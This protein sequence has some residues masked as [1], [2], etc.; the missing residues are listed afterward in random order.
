MCPKFGPS[1]N[2]EIF[3]EQGYKS[4]L[5]APEWLRIMG[6]DLYEYPC[7]RGIHI[8]QETAGKLKI[9][10]SQN[11]IE[12]SIHAPYY[13]NLASQDS[14]KILNSI[15]YI[16]KSVEAARWMGAK[17]V[18]FHP[19]SCAKIDREIAMRTVIESLKKTINIMDEMHYD[20]VIICPETM[21]KRNQI[22]TLDE[23]MELCRLDE[24]LIPTID[25]GHLN[26]LGRGSLKDREDYRKVLLKIKNSLGEFRLKNIHSHF[27]RIEYTDAGEKKHWTLKDEQYGPDFEPLAELLVEYQINATI[28]CESRGTMAEDA[29]ELKSIYESFLKF[30]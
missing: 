14:E 19:G 4:S 8:S 18:V 11:N 17:K 27:S 25:F 12:L 24:R 28:I 3:Y 2:S 6:L 26:A 10:A 5:E 22:G 29:K 23:I 9:N 1:G 13:I 21:G 16:I 7:S 30:N 20:D 15:E